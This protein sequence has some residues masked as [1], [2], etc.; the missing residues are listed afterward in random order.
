[1]AVRYEKPEG[2]GQP[3]LIRRLA[4]GGRTVTLSEL[5]TNVF[6][7]GRTNLLG[8]GKKTGIFRGREASVSEQFH[9]GLRIEAAYQ[10]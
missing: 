9:T 2:E 7:K 10:K 3:A 8:Q 1:M 6:V 5:A 4:K